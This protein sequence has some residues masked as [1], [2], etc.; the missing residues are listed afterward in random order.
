MPEE[1]FEFNKLIVHKQFEETLAEIK[2]LNVSLPTVSF[3]TEVDYSNYS[4]P[5]NGELVTPIEDVSK[6]KLYPENG[7]RKIKDFSTVS[8]YDESINRFDSLEGIAYFASHSLV[9]MGKDKYIPINYLTFYFYTKAEEI[10]KNSKYIKFSNDPERESKKDF[11]KD[12]ISFLLKSAPKSS[13]LLIDGPLIGGDV[14]TYMIRAIEDFTENGVIPIFFVKNSSSNL[15]TDRIDV[16]KKKFN[17]DMHWSYKFLR[18]GERTSFFK[19]VD[20]TAIKDPANSKVFCYL[21]TFDVS[22][23]RVEFHLSTFNKYR[24]IIPGIMDVIHY[25]ILV[26][27]DKNNPQVRP[28]A[29]AELYARKTLHLM[30]FQKIMKKVGITPTMNQNRFGW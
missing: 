30:N 26:Q 3:Q 6:E 17:S 15:V 9:M 14:Y 16:L 2:G 8:A 29:I 5:N 23:Q 11:I 4:F 12:K 21:K 19:Y 24:D 25:L 1:M 22:P 10:V 20:R 27:G 13:L 18:P 7:A 28:I